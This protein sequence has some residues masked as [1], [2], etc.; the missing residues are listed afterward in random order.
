MVWC[1]VFRCWCIVC[2]SSCW[3]VILYVFE[4]KNSKSSVEYKTFAVSLVFFVV[5]CEKV[6]VEI[7]ERFNIVFLI[8]LK[9]LFVC[10]DYL[11]DLLGL[12][13]C[14]EVFSEKAPGT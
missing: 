1:L 11:F 3:V 4:K 2:L 8:L 14:I 6:G 13:D 10:G 5:D 12:G 7:L 9:P